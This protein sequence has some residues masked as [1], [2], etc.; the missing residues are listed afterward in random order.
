MLDDEVSLEFIDALLLIKKGLDSD[1]LDLS[2]VKHIRLNEY[3]EKNDQT[4]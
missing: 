4:G 2:K 1:K 3:L